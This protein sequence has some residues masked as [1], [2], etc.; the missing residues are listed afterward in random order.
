MDGSYQPEAA[1]DEVAKRIKERMAALQEGEA[2]RQKV[3]PFSSPGAGQA[4]ADDAGD[5]A[6]VSTSVTD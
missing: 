1:K 3:E 4:S 6:S 5:N 2:K